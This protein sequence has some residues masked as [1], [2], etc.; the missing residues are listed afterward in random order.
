MNVYEDS[1][2]QLYILEAEYHRNKLTA[3]EI[4]RYGRWHK[5]ELPEYFYQQYGHQIPF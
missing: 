4:H 3:T 5:T 1:I 2:H